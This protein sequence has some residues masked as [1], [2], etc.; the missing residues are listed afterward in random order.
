[1]DKKLRISLVIYDI[2]CREYGNFETS[3]KRRLTCKHD[4]FCL[5][6]V[7]LLYVSISK[8]IIK[9][10][11]I[12]RKYRMTIIKAIKIYIKLSSSYKRG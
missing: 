6:D 1:M 2:D 3:H 9:Y 11:G 10:S 4:I 7:Q 5:I 8:R 12:D